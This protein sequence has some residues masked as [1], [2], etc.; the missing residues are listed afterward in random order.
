VA[1]RNPDGISSTVCVI[2]LNTT[3]PAAVMN[4][5]T[6]DSIDLTGE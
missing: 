5:P 6:A 3:S 1:V 4:C 2:Y